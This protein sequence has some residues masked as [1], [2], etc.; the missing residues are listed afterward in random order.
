MSKF[1]DKG[2]YTYFV[3]LNV[4]CLIECCLCIRDS[5]PLGEIGSYFLKAVGLIEQVFC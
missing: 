2:I 1:D 3:E 4:I 5:L